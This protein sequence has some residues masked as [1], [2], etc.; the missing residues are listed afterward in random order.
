MVK[1]GQC[2][3][4]QMSDID[5]EE[6]R[7]IVATILRRIYN[8]RLDTVRGMIT[9]PTSEKY[10]NYPVFV[11]LEEGHRFAPQNA[12]VV[13]TPL[14]KM[15]LSEGRKFGVGICI[16]SQRPGKLDQD[17][18]S[19]CMTQVIMRIVNPIDQQSI[20]SGVESAG[21]DILDELPA[22]TKGQAIIAGAAVNTPV[23]CQVRKRFTEDGGETPDAPK[24]WQEYFSEKNEQHRAQDTSINIPR[25]PQSYDEM[26]I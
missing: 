21:R 5:V 6:Q 16:I 9:D 10:L 26:P 8:A 2:T 15:V 19:Q 1:P 13:T 20:A 24:M 3:V 23:L 17:V 25:P 11:I 12:S 18:L 14:L 22:L 4:F 7:V